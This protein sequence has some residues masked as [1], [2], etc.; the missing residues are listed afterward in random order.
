MSSL[1]Q[2]VEPSFGDDPAFPRDEATGT[3]SSTR[4]GRMHNSH[5]A[6]RGPRIGRH[7]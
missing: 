2:L 1:A 4:S 7:A 3:G 6:T 5:N